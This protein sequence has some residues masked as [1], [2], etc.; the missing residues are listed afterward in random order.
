MGLVL[1]RQLS[2]G[3]EGRPRT[4]VA[5]PWRSGAV[6]TRARSWPPWAIPVRGRTPPTSSRTHNRPGAATGASG[7]R[8]TSWATVAR[9]NPFTPPPDGTV[10]PQNAPRL[11]GALCAGRRHWGPRRAPAPVDRVVSLSPNCGAAAG[12]VS[13]SRTTRPATLTVT[14][15]D[16]PAP[17]PGVESDDEGL[18]ADGAAAPGRPNPGTL[19]GGRGPGRRRLRRPDQER[20]GM[21]RRAAA[22]PDFWPPAHEDLVERGRGLGEPAAGVAP[23][24]GSEGS[25]PAP[26]GRPDQGAPSTISRRGDLQHS[27]PLA[28]RRRISAV[29]RQNPTNPR[30]PERSAWSTNPRSPPPASSSPGSH[31]S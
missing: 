6:D 17:A 18:G 28:N 20:S 22:P 12:T 30:P 25:R 26:R 11:K 21:P 29:V 15:P 31:S 1:V 5:L 2:R 14:D 16:P 13:R 24:R 7:G 8:S 23:S 3:P 10:G 4:V 27:G 9:A 19:V